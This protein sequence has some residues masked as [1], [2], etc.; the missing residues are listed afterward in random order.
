MNAMRQEITPTEV[1]APLQP[2][3]G[4]AQVGP[5]HDGAGLGLA[6]G[7]HPDRQAPVAGV[8]EGPDRP[9][10][11]GVEGVHVDPDVAERPCRIDPLDARF[12]DL[13]FNKSL[14]GRGSVKRKGR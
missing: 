2:P 13:A 4:P 7:L 11:D 10:V 8:Q 12:A 3:D 6:P 14:D 9:G 5:Y 1:F